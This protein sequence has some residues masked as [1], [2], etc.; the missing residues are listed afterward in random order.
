V[1]L[2]R[3]P[4][5][6]GEREDRRQPLVGRVEPLRPRVQLDPARPRVEAA[7]GLLD[8]GLVQVEA[9]ERDQPAGRA[10]RELERAVVRRAERGVTVGLVEAEHEGPRDPVVRHQLLEPVVVADHPVDVG[11]QMEMRVEDVGAGREH[12]ADLGVVERREL[13]C[14][15]H[16]VG[17]APTLTTPGALGGDG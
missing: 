4:A 16:D 2:D 11:A 5:L 7:G 10:L 3:Y 12:S 6:L 15:V 9:D 1:D 13:E 8:R 14:P 17:H